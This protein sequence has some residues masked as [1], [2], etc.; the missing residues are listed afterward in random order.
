MNSRNITPHESFISRADRTR[1]LGHGG[2]VIWM[3]GLS[4][5]GKSSLAAEMERRLMNQ[6]VHCFVLDG[7]NVRHGLNADL[8]F[9]DEDRKENI[10]RVG[11]VARL[12]VN[13][14]LVVLTSFISPFRE[15][16]SSVRSLFSKGTFFEIYVRCPLDLCESRDPKGLY[17]RAR[18]GEI[19][20]FTGIDS[21][22]EEPENPELVL[23]TSELPLEDCAGRIMEILESSGIIK[24]V[25]GEQDKR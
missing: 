15:D 22:Y 23:D 18:K 7:D 2:C 21:P 11:E 20:E 19:T 10:R 14:G 3:T 13:A 6:G 16:R 8:G 1:I 25:K 24:A 4:G 17:A 12:F 5:S 9:S